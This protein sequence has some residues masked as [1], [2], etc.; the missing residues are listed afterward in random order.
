[1]NL[2]DNII[3]MGDFNIDMKVRSYCQNRLIRVMNSV[4]LKQLV[5]EP[6]IVSSSET[7]IDLIFTNMEVEIYVYVSQ[8]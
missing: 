5:N 4:G 1:M 8:K 2:N 3:I 7:I 6:R